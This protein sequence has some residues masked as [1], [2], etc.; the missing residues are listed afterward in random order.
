MFFP[1]TKNN[2]ASAFWFRVERRQAKICRDTVNLLFLSTQLKVHSRS[3]NFE[4]ASVLPLWQPGSISGLWGRQPEPL[5]ACSAVYFLVPYISLMTLW[6]WVWNG[7]V[8]LIPFLLG[9][10]LN[11]YSCLLAVLIKWV[12]VLNDREEKHLSSSEFIPLVTDNILM[13]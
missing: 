7:L 11:K 9:M 13:V 6:S 1:L 8:P 3:L 4:R 10:K 12:Y 5:A 2:C